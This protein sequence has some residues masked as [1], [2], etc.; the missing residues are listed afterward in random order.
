L[1]EEGRLNDTR[2]RENFVSRLFAYARW[3]QL[4][5]TG[6]S[7]RALF[8]FHEQHKYQLMAHNQTGLRRL[9]HLLGN[10]E[11]SSSVER[12]AENYVDGFTEVMSRPP[13][14][15]NHTNVLQHVAG[16]VSGS[17][18]SSDREELADVIG[19]YLDGILPLIVPITLLRHYVRKFD[20]AYLKEQ[21]YLY[22]HPLE[23]MLLNQL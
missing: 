6:L 10:V 5:A 1:E 14:V 20:V 2:L 7:R 21:I 11:K 4:I 3:R 8:K 16:Y 9:G 18:D 13:T 17:L 19:D 15:K 12:L 22:S 23:L